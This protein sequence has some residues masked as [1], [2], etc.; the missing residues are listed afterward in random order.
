MLTGDPRFFVVQIGAFDGQTG[1]PIHEW[2]KRYGWNGV[3]VEPQRRYFKR[4]EATYAG[5]DGLALRN[6]ALAEQAGRR[7]FYQV[8]HDAPGIP[9]WVGQLASFDRDTILAHGHLVPNI[10]ELIEPVEVECVTFEDLLAGADRVDL[11]QIDAEGYDAEIVRM[12]DFD[13]WH[14]SIVN[15][16]SVHLSQADHDSV[17]GHLVRHGYKVTTTG[18]DTLA[19]AN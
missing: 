1:D 10:G 6:V 16:E 7:T 2:I 11:L 15:F 4:L 3:L 19:Y 18:V 17:I 13:R 9:E 12:F 5:Y 8:P 14:P